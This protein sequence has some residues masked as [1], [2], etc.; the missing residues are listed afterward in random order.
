MTRRKKPPPTPP[1]SIA[2]PT[3]S[4]FLESELAELEAVIGE[5]PEPDEKIGPPDAEREK[6]DSS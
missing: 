6:E 5:S 1:E 2:R 4:P 3:L